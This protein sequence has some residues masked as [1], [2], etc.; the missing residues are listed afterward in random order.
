MHPVSPV[1]PGE[2]FPEVVI[3]ENQDEYGNLPAVFLDNGVIVTRWRL[4]F[5][6]RLKVLF[7]GNIYLWMWTFGN[8]VT[9]VLIEIEKPQLETKSAELRPETA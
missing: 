9:P 1:I 4:S 7:A 3:A 2:K 8:P 6:E 5:R